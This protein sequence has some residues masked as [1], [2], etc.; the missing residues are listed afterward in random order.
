MYKI[1]HFYWGGNPLS[2]LRFLTVKSF[3]VFNP[4]WEVRFYVPKVH[5]TKL[6]QWVSH[7]HK[8][9]YTG[10]DYMA[11]LRNLGVEPRIFDFHAA[12]FPND[13]HEAQKS[14]FL[15]WHLLYHSG[16]F[17]SDTDVIFCKPLTYEKFDQGDLCI[18]ADLDPVV[19]YIAYIYSVKHNIF[20]G[21]I[22]RAAKR[23]S[24]FDKLNYQCLGNVLV[25]KCFPNPKALNWIDPV[26]NLPVKRVRDISNIFEKRNAVDMSRSVGLHWFGG[27][28]MSTKWENI[29][30]PEVI[31]HCNTSLCNLIREV[32]LC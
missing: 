10:H 15:R 14:D 9:R 28:P 26:V 16:G 27:H 31:P 22:L 30:T 21:Q 7:S 11:D 1:A 32:G 8:I 4:D 17:W 29:L 25:K 24:N 5:N 23:E 20:M 13:I 18:T 6:P 12:G 19:Y 2:Y 3:I